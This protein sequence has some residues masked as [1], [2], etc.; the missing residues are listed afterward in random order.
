MNEE[1]KMYNQL[2]Q[3]GKPQR[4]VVFATVSSVLQKHISATATEEEYRR[5]VEICDHLKT[6]EDSDSRT[7]GQLAKEYLKAHYT[8][9]VRQD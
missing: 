2:Q 5:A 9:F 7:G 8:D 3:M 6:S 4:L 1:M